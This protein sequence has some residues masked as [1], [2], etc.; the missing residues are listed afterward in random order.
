MVKLFIEKYPLEFCLMFGCLRSQI[1]GS[2]Y[3]EKCFTKLTEIEE[4]K[5]E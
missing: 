1:K 5:N 2:P 3:C 4:I